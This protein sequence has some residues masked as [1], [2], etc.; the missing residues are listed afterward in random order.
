MRILFWLR[1]AKQNKI[2]TVAIMCRIT[3][4]NTKAQFSTSIRVH[5]KKWDDKAKKIKG[6]ENFIDNDMLESIKFR[7]KSI[8]LEFENK[9]IQVTAEKIKSVFIGKETTTN[10]ITIIEVFKEYIDKLKSFKGTEMEITSGTLRNWITK[11]RN[12][13]FFL[14]DLKKTDLKVKDVNQYLGEDYFKYC[15]S[16]LNKK[17]TAKVQVAAV[18]TVLS[19]AVSKG[20]IN[21]NPFFVINLPRISRAKPD[22]LTQ[23]ELKL[24]ENFKTTVTPIQKTIDFAVFCAYTGLSYIDYMNLDENSIRLGSDNRNWIIGSRKKGDGSNK[25]GEFAVP[26]L[27]KATE[28]IKKYGGIDK[29]PKMTD[30]RFN[31]YLKII[32][33]ATGITKKLTTKIFRKTFAHF[34]LNRWNI[35]LVTVSAM[36]GHANI[37][38]TLDHYARITHEKIAEDMKKIK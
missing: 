17:T 21:Q 5:P 13:Q 26:L 35:D 25:Y 14:E 29:L 7:L 2:G 19:H 12:V 33:E 11:F 37:K 16:K 4:N 23:S 38:T 36:I 6:N 24:I 18:K 3:I 28:I 30:V 9:N 31:I 32:G 22:Y 34:A 10:D 15:I 20:Y 1:K 8:A 27:E